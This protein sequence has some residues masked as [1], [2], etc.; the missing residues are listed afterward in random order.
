MRLGISA[1]ALVIA[2]IPFSV[3]V[4][5]QIGSFKA[6]DP[7][8]RTGV[9]GAGGMLPGLSTL[10]QQVFNLGQQVFQEVASVQGT[11]QNTEAGLGP[12]FNM[13]SCAG[14]HASP[15]VGGSS[16]LVNPQVDVAKKEERSMRFPH[17]FNETGRSGKHGSNVI[18][19]ALLTEGCMPCLRSRAEAMRRDAVS[20]S[21]IFGRRWQPKM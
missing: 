19:T 13:D 17:L 6:R 18:P 8:V 10:E 11:V 16:P 15:V 3:E 4:Q 9:N 2:A 20:L 21:R 12:R 1:V 7:G 5:S 14:C